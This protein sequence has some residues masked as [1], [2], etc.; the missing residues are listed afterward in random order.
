MKNLPLFPILCCSLLFGSYAGL[1]QKGMPAVE[2][3][4]WERTGEA[5]D[6]VHISGYVLDD[7]E[8]PVI[9]GAVALYNNNVLVGS[10]YTDF[11]GHFS[12]SLS[13]HQSSLDYTIEVSYVVLQ[14]KRYKL[15]NLA[16][17]CYET[18]LRL[19]SDTCLLIDGRRHH[20]PPLIRAD[21]LTSG[22]IYNHS[23]LEKMP[24]Y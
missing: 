18:E 17:G 2:Q 13:S 1:A 16:S 5:D 3:I 10:M 20:Y 4:S 8:E 23:Q 12:F 19:S 7:T 21:N 6:T 15:G 14:T 9:F 22:A 24:A 11:D